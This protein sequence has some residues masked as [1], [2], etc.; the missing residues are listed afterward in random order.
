MPK[1]S[2]SG[3]LFGWCLPDDNNHKKCIVAFD[4]YGATVTCGCD[5]HPKDAEDVPTEND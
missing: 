2:L 5:C 4:S 3:S 1:Q